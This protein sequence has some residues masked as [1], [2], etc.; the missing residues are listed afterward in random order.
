VSGTL[1]AIVGIIY[2]VIS[3]EQFLKSNPAMGITFGAYALANVGLW[4]AASA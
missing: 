3:I 2:A 1:I 4:W